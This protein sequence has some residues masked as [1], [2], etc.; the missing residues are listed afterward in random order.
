[1]GKRLDTSPLDTNHS[2]SPALRLYKQ[3]IF[4][5][6][7]WFLN[8]SSNHTYSLH[9]EPTSHQIR[10]VRVCATHTTT[11]SLEVA[12]RSNIRPSRHDRVSVSVIKS[13]RSTSTFQQ[14]HVAIVRPS[15]DCLTKIDCECSLLVVSTYRQHQRSILTTKVPL[16]LP[17]P[18]LSTNHPISLLEDHGHTRL[19]QLYAGS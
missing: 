18:L 9:Q 7:P 2:F 11:D 14:I 16:H 4:L 17:L 1:M 13:Q 15:R 8:S 10:L 19:S 3:A 6:S 5:T 12:C